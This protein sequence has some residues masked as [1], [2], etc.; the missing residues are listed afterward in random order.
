MRVC[1]CMEKKGEGE[2]GE[3]KGGEKVRKVNMLEGKRGEIICAGRG[4][5]DRGNRLVGRWGVAGGAGQVGVGGLGG[6]RGGD[7]GLSGCGRKKRRETRR[8]AEASTRRRYRTPERQ[9]VGRLVTVVP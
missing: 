9:L 3:T 6:I 4:Q 1:V 2:L 5:K 7:N 8:G